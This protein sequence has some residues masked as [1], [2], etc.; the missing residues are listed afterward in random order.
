MEGSGEPAKKKGKVQI[1]YG[2]YLFKFL[3]EFLWI[4]LNYVLGTDSAKWNSNE[5]VGSD[6]I[7]AFNGIL[8][9]NSYE[10]RGEVFEKYRGSLTAL[11]K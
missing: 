5:K 9:E 8:T 1:N 2:K 3:S 10:K 4:Y 6:A 7:A 11:F